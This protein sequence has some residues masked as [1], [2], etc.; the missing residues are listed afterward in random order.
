MCAAIGENKKKCLE[1]EPVC[2]Y[3]KYDECEYN[4]SRAYDL[5]RRNAKAAADAKA[6]AAAEPEAARCDDCHETHCVCKWGYNDAPGNITVN[7]AEPGS[8]GI[9]FID[10]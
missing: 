1:K 4:Y 8:L 10:S 6:A 7:F 3:N 5:S 9:N 2:K